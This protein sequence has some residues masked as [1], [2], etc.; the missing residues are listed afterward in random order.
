MFR[1]P[2]SRRADRRAHPA[3][4]GTGRRL[5]R[6]ATATACV[7]NGFAGPAPQHSP[8]RAR[9]VAGERGAGMCACSVPGSC[10]C[11]A[12]RPVRLRRA[13]SAA[14]RASSGEIVRGSATHRS[15]AA[16]RR[17]AAGPCRSV[18]GP[19]L[20]HR[21]GDLRPEA[22]CRKSPGRGGGGRFRASG[23]PE[24][25]RVGAAGFGTV[26]LHDQGPG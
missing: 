13:R 19:W 9:P 5:G 1:H 21:S 10:G 4:G 26:P 12:Q 8:D 11:G 23:R 7:R 25:R 20:V 6:G 15:P 14:R 16:R 3:A 18:A 24:A 17:Y 22:M 2:L